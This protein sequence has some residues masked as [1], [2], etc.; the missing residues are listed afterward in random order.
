MFKKHVITSEK[1]LGTS[2]EVSEIR[3]C[4]IRSRKQNEIVSEDGSYPKKIVINHRGRLKQKVLQVG[5]LATG[6]QKKN[7][8]KSTPPKE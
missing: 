4:K 1:F 7:W 8:W 2:P 3:F 6:L 5:I